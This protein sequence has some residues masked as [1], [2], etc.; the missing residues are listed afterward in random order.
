M[1]RWGKPDGF[2]GKVSCLYNVY[3]LH[4]FAWS[5][6]YMLT[7]FQHICIFC[8]YIYAYL[9]PALLKGHMSQLP[10]PIANVTAMSSC[11][12]CMLQHT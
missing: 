1:K 11:T 3:K 5:H 8:L 9:Y 6:G 12:L 4:L 2:N 10:L 7:H